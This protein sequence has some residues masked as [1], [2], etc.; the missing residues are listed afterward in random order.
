MLVGEMMSKCVTECTEDMSLSDVYDLICKCDH[1]LVVVIDSN[2]HRVPIGVVSE[3]SICE[4]IIA[5]GRNPR[6]LI[7]GSCMDS[8]IKT[9]SESDLVD[10][11]SGEGLDGITAIVVTNVNRQVSG[12]IPKSVLANLR[13]K[14]ARTPSQPAARSES[15]PVRTPAT[16]EIPAFGWVQ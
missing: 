12:L 1:G 3:R 14:T 5:R 11:V 15:V 13:P 2:A 8:R 4:Q 10:A 9:V 7:A 16:R 6:S